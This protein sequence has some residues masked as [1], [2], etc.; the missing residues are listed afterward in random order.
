MLLHGRRLQ[1]H[2]DDL[3]SARQ[4]NVKTA[5]SHLLRAVTGWA[6]LFLGR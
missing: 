4:L 5:I 1:P 3:M 2:A 6:C